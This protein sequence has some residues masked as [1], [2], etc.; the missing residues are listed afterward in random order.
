M[1]D[2]VGAYRSAVSR[3]AERW[4]ADGLP[5]HA[6][7][8]R[9]ADELDGLRGQL[10]IEGLWAAAPSMVTATLDDALG[11]GLAV[12]ERFA[13]TIGVRIHSLGLMPPPDVIIRTCRRYR[14][15][16]LGL[17]VLQF[18]SEAD[19]SIIAEHLPARTR[20]V[21]GG[22]VFAGDPDFARRTGVHFAAG[23]V[24]AFLK[25]MVDTPAADFA[26]GDPLSDG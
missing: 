23:D 4:L 15:T 21:A 19:L 8:Y 20:I 24:A 9:A 13:R 14:P 3:L 26:P 10:G 12:I 2:P 18:D 7:L 16:L 11:Q 6:Q 17:T 22:P 25:Y 1:D 5:S